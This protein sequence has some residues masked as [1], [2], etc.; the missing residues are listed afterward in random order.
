MREMEALLRKGRG[1]GRENRAGRASLDKNG[2][3]GTYFSRG[4][5]GRGK[6]ERASENKRG[7]EEGSKKSWHT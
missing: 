1:K 5:E 7:K 3:S 6:S 4:G 2:R